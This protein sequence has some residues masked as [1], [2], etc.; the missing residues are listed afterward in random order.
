MQAGRSQSSTTVLHVVCA[1][2]RVEKTNLWK[3]M[4][5]G[6]LRW[7]GMLA[8]RVNDDFYYNLLLSLLVYVHVSINYAPKSSSGRSSYEMHSASC[9]VETN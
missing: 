4:G 8:F 1:S 5:R 3:H 7:I 9:A 2:E 6:G